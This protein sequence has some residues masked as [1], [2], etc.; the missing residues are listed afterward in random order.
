MP[1]GDDVDL[2]VSLAIG[3]A[4]LADD[5]A[6]AVFRP[7]R[8]G[9]GDVVDFEYVY[10]NAAAR[11]MIGLGDVVGRRLL[12]LVPEI[13]D[14]VVP[15]YRRVHE[16]GVREVLVVPNVIRD[17][18]GPWEAG[19]TRIDVRA[20]GDLVLSHSRDA[21]DEQTN[22]LAAERSEARLRALLVNAGEV[23]SVYTP[24]GR[25][26]LYQ[27]P[28]AWRVLGRDG[29]EAALDNVHPD[30]RATAEKTLGRVVAD[31]AGAVGELELRLRHADGRWLW[32]HARGSN[33]ADDPDVGG[34]VINFW[35]ITERR[36]LAE[37]LRE[38]ALHDPLTGLPNR[39]YV[40]AELARALARTARTPGEVGLILCDVDYFK[41]VNDALGH[42]AGDE[43][44]VQV[45]QRLR[46]LVR[47][48]DTVG[49]LGGDEFIVV[50]EDLHDAGELTALTARLHDGL[51]SVYCLDGHDLPVTVTV[52]ASAASS[53]TTATEL[54]SE[55]DSA[56]YEAKRAGRDGAQVFDERVHRRGRDR[57]IRQQALRRGVGAGELVLHYQ[58]KID[59]RT[60]M[61]VAA[62]A[63]VRWQHPTDGLLL[64]SD[65]LPLAEESALI[66]DVER[67]V[68][69]TAMCHAAR[70][71]PVP[72]PA[73]GGPLDRPL[74]LV[75]INLSGRHLT[76]PA[77]L[78]HLDEALEASGLDPSRVELEITETVL[79][80]DLDAA[81]RI[82]RAVRDRGFGVALDDFG[83]GYSSLT[84]LQRLPVDTVKLD[85][86]FIADLLSPEGYAPD[87]LGSVT[88]LAHALGKQVVAEGVERPEQHDYLVGLGCDLAQGYLYGR[89]TADSPFVLAPGGC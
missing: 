35:D 10:V 63:L 44:L 71:V 60:G 9:S 45:A 53:S 61:A 49:R 31:G 25:T 80:T 6:W 20:A 77:L 13:H 68:L 16:T 40:D 41:S 74:P 75:N 69:R 85:R 79:V 2:D 88:A 1:H 5:D 51:R 72:P 67:W 43:L 21:T 11:D 65:F 78:D 34:V 50:C 59:L 48:S 19:W 27:S 76:H 82:L 64:P 73:Q 62:E 57:A 39:R 3:A 54:L 58:P 29:A 14:S 18:G 56:L 42:P 30:D 37:Q 4:M 86:S 36:E 47:P 24:D 66:V 46:R 87:I 23:I 22:A 32:V 12:D 83:T 55:A 8:D 70:W 33:F 38:Q 81:A 84:W 89:P 26:L 17:V 7:V 15:L 28:S 52:G